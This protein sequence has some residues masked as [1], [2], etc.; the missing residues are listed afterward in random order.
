MLLA[1]GCLFH[2]TPPAPPNPIFASWEV[3]TLAELDTLL[4]VKACEG[5]RVQQVFP[6]GE[7]LIA[8]ISRNGPAP[9]PQT[10]CR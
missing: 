4:T 10:E 8:V 3:S 9:A 1:S 5:W 7:K 6:R 2:K